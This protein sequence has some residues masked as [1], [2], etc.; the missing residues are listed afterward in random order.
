MLLDGVLQ[1]S[2]DEKMWRSASSL[3]H[4]IARIDISLA[5]PQVVTFARQPHPPPVSLA[6]ILLPF[7][8]L[9]LLPGRAI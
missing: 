3:V 4:G 2:T 6:D 5:T 7:S 9:S 1:Q 8:L